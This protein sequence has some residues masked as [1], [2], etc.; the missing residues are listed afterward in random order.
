MKRSFF[1]MALF[2]IG[3]TTA[4]TSCSSD[5]DDVPVN[6]LPSENSLAGQQWTLVEGDETSVYTFLTETAMS[7]LV[8]PNLKAVSAPT[9]YE[10]T[11]SYDKA[12]ASA[13]FN[14]NGRTRQ[15][16]DIKYG[17]NQ[18]TCKIDGV[19]V[20]VIVT[21]QK[22]DKDK[23]FLESTA[24]EFVGL[25]N[26][27]QFKSYT[28]IY[29]ALE[30]SNANAVSDELEDVI[31]KLMKTTVEETSVLKHYRYVFYAAGVKGEYELK[32]DKKWYR[33]SAVA[34]NVHRIIFN[35]A[36]GRRCVVNVT[37]S[38]QEKEVYFYDSN[39]HVEH[40]YYD[41]DTWRY[42][43]TESYTK[44]TEYRAKLPEYIQATVTR[45]GEQLVFASIRVDLSKIR[46]GMKIDPSKDSF[47]MSYV[48]NIK[49]LVDISAYTDYAA[50]GESKAGFSVS[51]NGRVI[52]TATALANTALTST[53]LDD[54]NDNDKNNLYEA[55]FNIDILGKIQ[56]KGT[57]SN[58]S[59]VVNALDAKTDRYSYESVKSQA[60]RANSAMNIKMYY[61]GS[62]RE[63]GW[64]NFAVD[65]KE[66]S[67]YDHWDSESYS[68]VYVTKTKYSLSSAINFADGS[69]YF[70]EKYFTEDAFR[71]LVDQF[72]KLYDEVKDQIKK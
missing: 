53:S 71:S 9:T 39:K 50:Q 49:D 45:G 2:A 5:D 21:Y 1:V 3:L 67:V 31:D 43:V 28:S 33:N 26:K 47:G 61:N 69:S 10:G 52:L 8:S 34:D 6:I 56:L 15:L 16:T 66:V 37:T 35:D 63:S 46:E 7:V 59:T 62:S 44:K 13:I 54:F 60:D 4:M 72:N 68:S 17:G 42:I 24:K 57:S 41:Y 40:G 20:T 30:K 55:S 70:V 14:Y 51:K 58:M 22:S 36:D 48:L 12:A 27:D 23:E 19:P 25:F 18:L 38:G 11:Y 32:S 65:S 29:N 64:L